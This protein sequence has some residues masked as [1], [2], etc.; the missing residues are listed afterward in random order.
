MNPLNNRL[1]TVWKQQ[2]LE[3][4]GK[5]LYARSKWEAN[6]ACYLEFLKQNNKI[7]EWLHEPK[8]W[9]FEG[10]KRG[11]VSFKPDFEATLLDDTFLVIEVKGWMDAKSKTKLARMA[12][13]YPHVKVKLVDKDWFKLNTKILKPIVKGWQ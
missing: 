2:W 5:R 6:Y 10:I 12:K 11:V 7:K 1:K 13:Y 9:W 4:G 8:T 3:I